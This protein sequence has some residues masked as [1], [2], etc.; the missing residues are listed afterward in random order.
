MGFQPVGISR[1][2]LLPSEK[3]TDWKPM[4]QIVPA[5]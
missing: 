3:Y 4:L 1:N 5:M 2:V